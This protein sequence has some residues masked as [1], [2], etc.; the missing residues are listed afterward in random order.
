ME[1]SLKYVVKIFHKDRLLAQETQDCNDDVLDLKRER[2]L[3][4]GDQI[5]KIA[6]KAI[7]YA[8][9]MHD[10][11]SKVGKKEAPYEGNQDGAND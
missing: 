5:S 2:V 3:Y 7:K 8:L 4:M 1:K 9:A 6:T 11:E 10:E